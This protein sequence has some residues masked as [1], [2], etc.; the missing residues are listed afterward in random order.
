M[1]GL[2][3]ATNAEWIAAV[4]ADPAR[5]LVDHAHCEKKAASMA[6]SLINRYPERRELV[7]AMAQLAQEEMEHFASVTRKI[8]ERGYTL[9]HD[10]GDK[11]VQALHALIRTNEPDRLIDTLLV[12]SI[13][14]ARS[15]E[16]FQ[17][18]AQHIRD[19][20]LRQ[21]Y[22]S[23]VE[24]E[25]QHRTL[26]VRLARTYADRSTVD[27]RLEVLNVLEGNIVESLRGEPVMHG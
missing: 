19:E 24:S 9:K 10:T 3:S 2:T 12:S 8:Y 26:F 17:L 1:L 13:V 27:A 22:S 14:E 21:F 7:E 11:Y 15:C 23:L 6:I 4:L 16:R 5:V 25:A 18:L 20:D